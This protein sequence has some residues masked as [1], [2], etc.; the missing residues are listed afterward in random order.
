MNRNYPDI[1]YSWNQFQS[2]SRATTWQGITGLLLFLYI[3]NLTVGNNNTK[4]SNNMDI[5]ISLDCTT[6]R[7][8]SATVL[9]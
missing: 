3:S 9:W 4:L 1:L 6:T 5:D 8:Q 7:L 2:V